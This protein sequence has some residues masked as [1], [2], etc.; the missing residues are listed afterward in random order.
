VLA[1]V[2]QWYLIYTKPRLEAEAKLHLGRQG[3]AVLFPKLREQRVVRRR[4][5][6]VE[7][8]LFKRYIFIGGH[9]DSAWN[10]VR[11]TRGV[12]N[13]VRF[14]GQAASVPVELIRS[15]ES[16]GELVEAGVPMFTHG[17]TVRIGTGALAGLEA[18]FLMADGHQRAQVLLNIM[19]ASSVVTLNVASLMPA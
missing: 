8:P 10:V 13:I 2:P 14:G 11:S 3:F 1:D 7:E 9:A 12:S 19:G 15:L 6:W 5:Q 4:L 18:I 17:Q 16:A